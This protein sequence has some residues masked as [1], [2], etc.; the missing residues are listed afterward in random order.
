MFLRG[1]AH[2]EWKITRGGERRTVKEDEYFIDDKV[3]AWGDNKTSE[4]KL[5][6]PP[7]FL[8]FPSFLPAVCVFAEALKSA[9]SACFVLLLC[10]HV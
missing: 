8:L 3:T 7:L 4:R 9:I 6:S 10:F 1:K 5:P 2:V